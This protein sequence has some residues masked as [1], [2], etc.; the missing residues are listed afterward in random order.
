M[1]LLSS[2]YSKKSARDVSEAVTD[3]AASALAC[4]ATATPPDGSGAAMAES[5]AEF[6]C[7]GLPG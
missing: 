6:G 5:A 1:G 2:L 7:D 4:R 3:T